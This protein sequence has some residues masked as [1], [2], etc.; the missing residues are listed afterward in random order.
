MTETPISELIDVAALE[1]FINEQVPGERGPIQVQKHVAGFSN[2]TFYVSR[3]EQ[4][5]VL[6]R[7][8]RG[9]L[10]PTAHDVVREYRYLS[11][12]WGRAR[13]PRP[14]AVCEDTSVIGAP[15]Y[16]MERLDGVVI[17]GEVPAAYDTPEGRRK[18]AEELVDG[19]VELHAVDWQAAG[20]TGK[21]E[22]YLSRQIE[23]WAKQWELTRP[24]TRELPGLDSVTDWL[25]AR[26]PAEADVSVVHGD[27]KLDNTIF[28]KDAP[29][30]LG[31]LDWE[32]ATI[33]DPLADLGWLLSTWGDPG[34]PPG[35]RRFQEERAVLTAADGFPSRE[36]MAALYEARSGRSMKHFAFYSVLAVYK[37]AV[38][39]EGLYMH[40]LEKTAS[41]PGA[42]DFEWYVPVLIDRMHRLMGEY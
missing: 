9:P 7:P 15:F 3:G 38:I 18:L 8:P 37:M 1:R 30:L 27:Y 34:D 4:Q 12:L 28:A 10:L 19:L 21:G 11:A 32:M 25:R 5:W 29:R 41:N 39:L 17:R 36:E 33:G 6:R 35:T 42:A 24:R 16:L 22:T 31:I 20:L 2:E 14:V 40:Y 23:R 13:V 26:L